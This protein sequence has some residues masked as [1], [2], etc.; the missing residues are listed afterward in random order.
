[1]NDIVG[2]SISGIQEDSKK[3]TN[4]NNKD[5]K[6]KSKE[7]QSTFDEQSETQT[8]IAQFVTNDGKTTGS[9]LELP[10]NTS[11]TQLEAIIN[12][13]LSNVRI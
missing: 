1:M 4:M 5:K 3:H 2:L 9:Q 10:V 11:S 8:I 13:L 7:E 6:K 12:H